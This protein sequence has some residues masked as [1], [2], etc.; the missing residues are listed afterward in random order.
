MKN[1]NKK[2]LATGLLL[3]AIALVA[4]VPTFAA[5][6]SQHFQ[7]ASD[8]NMVLAGGSLRI[9]ATIKQAEPNCTYTV[10]LTVTGPGGV[11]ASASTTVLTES[12][13]NGVAS[14]A[15]PSGF[16]GSANTAT[17]GTYTVTATFS[18]GYSTGSA[19]NTF[20]VF[21]SSAST[22]ASPNSNP[23]GK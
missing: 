1:P 3:A 4:I 21:N 15:F 16:S 19:T 2:Y 8:K 14:V 22:N 23:H 18:C 11:N 9:I 12:G 5:P 7:V 6:A 20:T 10:Q 13:G 17:S